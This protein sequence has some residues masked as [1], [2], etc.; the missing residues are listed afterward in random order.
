[1][2][3]AGWMAVRNRAAPLGSIPGLSIRLRWRSSRAA[4]T[5]ARANS[6]AN[7]SLARATGSRRLP[8]RSKLTS[9]ASSVRLQKGTASPQ[10][11]V[12]RRNQLNHPLKLDQ[13]G[14]RQKKAVEAAIKKFDW[15][16]K[17]VVE[18][19]GTQ[20]KPETEHR[21]MLVSLFS[22]PR[23]EAAELMSTLQA[24]Y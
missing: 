21:T 7:L 3:Q 12:F 2:A 20:G 14:P 5:S 17:T 19:S 18:L 6:P 15:E 13:L 9:G 4:S 22:E 16:S 1:K 23:P 10:I 8:M 24:I 11:G